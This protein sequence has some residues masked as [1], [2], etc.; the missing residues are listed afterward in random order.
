MK[1]Y[2]V[3]AEDLL[4]ERMFEVFGRRDPEAPVAISILAGE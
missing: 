1:G 3:E 4:I 2:A